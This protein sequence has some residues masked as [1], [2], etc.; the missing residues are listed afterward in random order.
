VSI[1]RLVVSFSAGGGTMRDI[2]GNID[3]NP[4]AP[5]RRALEVP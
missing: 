3:T 1:E 4:R 5:A 2:D